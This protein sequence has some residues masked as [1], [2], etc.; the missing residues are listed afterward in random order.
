MEWITDRVPEEPGEY[1]VT[2]DDGEYRFTRTCEWWD[3]WIK[4][5]DD[6]EVVAWMDMPEPYE[7]RDV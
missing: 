1:L 3:G 6:L 5:E 7:R 2:F 4:S